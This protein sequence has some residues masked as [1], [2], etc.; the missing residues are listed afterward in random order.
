VYT[1]P[2]F[3]R[4]QPVN[5]LLSFFLATFLV[6]T[7][8]GCGNIFIRGAIDPGSSS[9]SG[10]VSIVQVSAVIGDGGSTVQVT[11]VTFLQDGTSSTIGFCGDERSRFP[12]QESIRANFTPGQIC[13]SIVTIVIN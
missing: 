4:K 2:E 11:F 10:M 13:A 6:V 12:V 5:R 3:D 1:L 8:I 7:L 9:V